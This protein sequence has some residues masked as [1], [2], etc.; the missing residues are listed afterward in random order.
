MGLEG[1][2]AKRL[3]SSYVPGQ[4]ST[5]WLKI[6]VARTAEF[7]IAGYVQRQ[8]EKT[9]SALLLCD[10]EGE[11]LLFRGKVGSGFTEP[12]RR[13]FFNQLVAAPALPN[14]P[15]DGPKEAVWRKCG[16]RCRVRFFEETP[17]GSLRSPVYIGLVSSE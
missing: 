17:D 12:Q 14:P 6:K 10:R 2:V 11:R 5:H 7:E 16:L 1:V 4:R 9:V 8:G 13:E 3:D 15:E